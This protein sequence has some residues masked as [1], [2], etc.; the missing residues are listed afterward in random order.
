MKK[1]SILL[2]LHDLPYLPDQ[3]ITRVKTR[4]LSQDQVLYVGLENSQE[5]IFSRVFIHWLFLC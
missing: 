3:I 5:I 1:H 4:A 2:H